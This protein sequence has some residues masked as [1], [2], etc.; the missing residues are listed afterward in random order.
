MCGKTNIAV[1]LLVKQL[2]IQTPGTEYL[3]FFIWEMRE[4]E[5]VTH[6]NSILS[7]TEDQKVYR[8]HVRSNC[9]VRNIVQT[10]A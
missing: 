5:I 9:L 1:K 4:I 8:T 6:C 10:A 3:K 7:F 2:I